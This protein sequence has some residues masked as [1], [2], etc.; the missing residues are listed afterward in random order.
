MISPAW[1]GPLTTLDDRNMALSMWPLCPCG[2]DDDGAKRYSAI[3]Q[4]VGYG[5][6]VRF[7]SGMT[8]VM[9]ADPHFQPLDEGIVSLGQALENAL[10]G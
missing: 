2:T 8:M 7:P 5:G 1:A 3:G 9:R 6:L 4:T 10:R